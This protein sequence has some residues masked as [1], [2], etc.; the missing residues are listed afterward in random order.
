MMRTKEEIGWG[1]E[2]NVSFHSCLIFIL[3]DFHSTLVYEG[4]LSTF[5]FADIAFFYI[6]R[7]ISPENE[8]NNNTVIGFL[9]R[10]ICRVL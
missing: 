9:L 10:Q 4:T 1:P 2:I 7:N 3:P 5:C 6:I 8:T